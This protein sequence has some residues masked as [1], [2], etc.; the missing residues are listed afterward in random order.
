MNIID[1][2]LMA[3]L[4]GT[5]LHFYFREKKTIASAEKSKAKPLF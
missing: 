2:I 4:T 3:V 5:M 1:W